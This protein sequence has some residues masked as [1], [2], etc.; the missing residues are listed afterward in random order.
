MKDAFEAA[1]AA[2][3][4]Q[5]TK[6]DLDRFYGRTETMPEVDFKAARGR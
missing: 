3:A 1:S 2:S 4:Q 5:A 6:A